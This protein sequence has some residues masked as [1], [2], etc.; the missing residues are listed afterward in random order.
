[1]IRPSFSVICLSMLRLDFYKI[2]IVSSKDNDVR[3]QSGTC[4]VCNDLM[5]ICGLFFLPHCG[6]RT[7]VNSSISHGAAQAYRHECSPSLHCGLHHTAPY[8]YHSSLQACTSILPRG[9]S[10][11][12]PPRPENTHPVSMWDV[13]WSS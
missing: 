5:K 1:M 13:L 9:A 12:T 8:H 3:C 7:T 10:P 2:V 6:V 4:Y 11:R